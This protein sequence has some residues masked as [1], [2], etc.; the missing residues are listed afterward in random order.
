M[1]GMHSVALEGSKQEIDAVVVLARLPR[2]YSPALARL[3]PEFIQAEYEAWYLLSAVAANECLMMG[4]SCWAG[5]GQ[6]HF[7]IDVKS[8]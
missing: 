4:A 6:S 3:H 7:C 5:N 8:H 2:A 1:Y